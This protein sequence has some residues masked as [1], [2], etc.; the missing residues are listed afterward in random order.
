MQH[1]F[2]A[3]E[4]RC[5]VV[6]DC[7]AGQE[8]RDGV[9]RSGGQDPPDAAPADPFLGPWLPT[10]PTPQPRMFNHQQAPL[11]NGYMFLIGGYDQGNEVVTVYRAP[12]GGDGTLGDWSETTALPVRRALSAA[13]ASDGVIYLLGGA[14]GGVARRTV[15]FG[16]VDGDGEVAEWTPTTSLPDPLKAHIGLAANGFVYVIAGGDDENTRLATTHFAQIEEGG[17]GAWRA[18]PAL[19]EPRAQAAG[20]IAGEWIYV[21][22]G[23]DATEAARATVYRASLDPE[24]GEVGEWTAERDLPGPLIQATAVADAGY[25]YVIGGWDGAESIDVLH[26]AIGADG[27]LGDWTSNTALPEPR[28]LH[29][30]AVA[31]DHI[32]VLAG[33]ASG[34]TD[35]FHAATGRA[36]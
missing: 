3:T 36:R 17:L 6:P 22:G 14:E 35:V 7:P 2:A 26:A 15:F 18:G 12:T 8:C 28:S 4:F 11:V 30:S 21:I 20:A 10:T 29:A 19:P 32:F 9:C 5:D 33:G 1:D 23:D 16:Q 31:D 34:S 25:L 24:S 13:A 27:S